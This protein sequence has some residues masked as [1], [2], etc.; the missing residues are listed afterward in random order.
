MDDAD[1]AESV[2]QRR[3]ILGRLQVSDSRSRKGF[4]QRVSQAGWKLR[5][6]ADSIATKESE[7]KRLRRTVGPERKRDVYRSSHLFRRRLGATRASKE[8]E[9]PA[10]FLHPCVSR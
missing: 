4:H 7:S 1:G 8:A 9:S 10:L 6:E 5:R 2:G 3:W